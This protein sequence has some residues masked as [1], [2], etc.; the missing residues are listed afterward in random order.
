MYER[1]NTIKHGYRSNALS[2]AQS[3]FANWQHRRRDLQASH[4]GS[5]IIDGAYSPG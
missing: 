1:D 5:R 3:A 4:V 2:L